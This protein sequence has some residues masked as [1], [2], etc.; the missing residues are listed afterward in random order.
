MQKFII[1]VKDKNTGRDVISPYILNSLIGLGGYS[2]Q[3]SPLG[4]VVIVVS[5]IVECY[6]VELEIQN[7]EK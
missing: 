5:I 7:D 1:S 3:F 4:V 2:E 6:F